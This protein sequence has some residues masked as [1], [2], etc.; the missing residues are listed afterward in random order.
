MDRHD[1]RFDSLVRLH[2]SVSFVGGVVDW[3]GH[4]TDGSLFRSFT[5]LSVLLV[6]VQ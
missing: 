4:L 3:F 5:L 6:I 1:L 2:V